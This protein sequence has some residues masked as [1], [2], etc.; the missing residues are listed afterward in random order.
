MGLGTVNPQSLLNI[1]INSTGL[2]GLLLNTLVPNL[3][4][5]LVSFLYLTYNGLYTCMLVADEWSR[6]AHER[7][8]L[9]VTSHSGLQRST[10]YLQLPY[11][12]STPLLVSSCVLHWLV[13]QTI[14]IARVTAS[15]SDG[16]EDH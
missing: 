16:S 2:S 1:G 13:S 10:Y 14:F 15:S 11:M 3:P 9:R 8:S 4:Q 12:Y 6:F 5:A 7:K